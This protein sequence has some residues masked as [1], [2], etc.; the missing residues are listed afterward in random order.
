MEEMDERVLERLHADSD[1]D[2]AAGNRADDSSSNSGLS[3]ADDWATNEDPEAELPFISATNMRVLINDVISYMCTQFKREQME[4]TGKSNRSISASMGHMV[5]RLNR[6]PHQ[7]VLQALDQCVNASERDIEPQ[8]ASWKS[9]KLLHRTS[10]GGSGNWGQPGSHP[11]LKWTR[12]SENS[13]ER[14]CKTTTDWGASTRKPWHN[15]C[16]GTLGVWA[17]GYQKLHWVFMGLLEEIQQ[18]SYWM[19][20]NAR[21][22]TRHRTRGRDSRA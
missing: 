16:S 3:S 1:D 4:A 2:D 17:T 11:D 18:A 19:W 20:F 8:N 10:R 12:G 14:T 7:T 9:F 21:I 6:S 15:V 5:R 22:I 13:F